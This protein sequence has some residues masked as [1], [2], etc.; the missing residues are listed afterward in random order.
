MTDKRRLLTNNLHQLRR[1]LFHNFS[2][3]TKTS[4]KM[5]LIIT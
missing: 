1:Q 3:R 2:L 4:Q 5:M